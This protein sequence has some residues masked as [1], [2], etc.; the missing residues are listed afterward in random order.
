MP[1][2][3]IKLISGADDGCVK[4]HI[5]EVKESKLPSSQS[6]SITLI[7]Q[8]KKVWVT[9]IALISNTQ[10]LFMAN[11]KGSIQHY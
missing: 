6:K 7:Q 5:F 8:R 11:N 1:L 9:S 10:T 4:E 2:N 3:A